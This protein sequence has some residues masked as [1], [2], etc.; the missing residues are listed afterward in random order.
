MSNIF[1]E[2]V[3]FN[4]QAL[5][6]FAKQYQENQLYHKYCQN[7]GVNPQNISQWQQIPA[8]PTEAFKLEE[9]LI[10]FAEQEIQGYF[11]SSGTT[12]AVKGKHYHRSLDVYR[13]SIWQGWCHA[14]L[15]QKMKDVDT[16]IFLT[17][18]SQRDPNS[19]LIEMFQTLAVRQ[20]FEQ[21][22]FLEHLKLSAYQKVVEMIQQQ[23][24]PIAIFGPAL[25]YHELQQAL[26]GKS[27]P[28]K[29]GSWAL[30]TGGYKGQTKD[31]QR[32][33]L[34]NFIQQDLAVSQSH[35]INEYGMCELSSPAYDIGL[36]GK[37]QL[38]PWCRVQV[39][40]WSEKRACKIGE[41][42]YLKLYDLANQDS[43]MAIATQ[44]WAVCTGDEHSFQL[45]GREAKAVAKGCSLRV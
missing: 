40:N 17:L 30:E 28:L 45:I 4:Q 10:A 31:Y 21:V 26:E 41:Q 16:A 33:D 1:T 5:L 12:R 32:D 42:G 15:A 37:H 13:E 29:Q 24:G 18:S 8:I 19:S 2:P 43:V 36:T 22:Y 39:W 38:P 20:G 14:G 27:M 7:K 23:D 44:D 35:I 6:L 9:P 3:D 11:Q 34:L 25:A